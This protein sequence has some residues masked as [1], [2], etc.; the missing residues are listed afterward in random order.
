MKCNVC[1]NEMKKKI[2]DV[3]FWKQHQLVLFKNIELIECA[4]CGERIFSPESTD[5]ILNR[6]KQKA[7]SYIN[8]PVYA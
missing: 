6:L 1:Q 5:I 8:I 4:V 2:D 7:H 3:E